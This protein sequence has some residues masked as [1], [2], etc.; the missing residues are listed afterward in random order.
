MARNLS[1]YRRRAGLVDIIFP[2][3]P[4]AK[5]YQFEAASNWDAVMNPFQVV[6]ARGFR[7]LSVPDL[8]MAD[9]QF[10][11][12]T[13]FTFNPAD[14]TVSVPA[15]DDSKPFYIRIVQT[16]WDG[17]VHTAEAQHL[18]LP[19]SP[20]PNRPLVLKGTAPAGATIADSFEVQLPMQCR[21]FRFQTDG[22][23][24]ALV[25]FE[26]SGPE[27]RVPSLSV[28]FTTVESTFPSGTQLFLRGDGVATVI[29]VLAEIHNNPSL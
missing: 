4:G 23:T 10:R 1:V 6:P 19:Y 8:G 13:R 18:I 26:P 5:S 16:D 29:E 17:T 9:S 22:V 2:A 27:I 15:V 21:N 20:A 7:S 14:Y 12:K 25:A 11:G 24:D 3:R 28:E